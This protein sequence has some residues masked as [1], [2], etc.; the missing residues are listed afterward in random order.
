MDII[1]KEESYKIIGAS[2]EVYNEKDFGFHEAVYQEC[3]E[4][5]SG[6]QSI[7]FLPQKELSLECK[8]HPLEQKYIPDIL[9]FDK[10]VVELK[11]VSTLTDEHRGQVLNYLRATG[12]KLGIL[13]NFGNPKKL[14]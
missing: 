2:L 1:Y 12:M 14:E 6:F 3:M 9:C 11:A 13:I 4:L 7:P 10:I 8:G 5:E